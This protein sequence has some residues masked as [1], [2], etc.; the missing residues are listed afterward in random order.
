[1]RS[2]YPSLAT[3]FS[4]LSATY[5]PLVNHTSPF[6]CN[7]S[8]IASFPTATPTTRTSIIYS[9]ITTCTKSPA[10][11]CSATSDHEPINYWDPANRAP[12]Q[13]H[14]GP[15]GY[16]YSGPAF[17]KGTKDL[18]PALSQYETNGDSCWGTLD[19]PHLPPWVGA[20]VSGSYTS[21]S[22]YGNSSSA[23]PPWGNA[24]ATGTNPYTSAPHTNVTRYY[25]FT[26]SYMDIA[27]DGVKKPGLVINGG[28][29]GPLIEANW[30][31]WIE[32]K[33]TNLLDDEGTTLHWHGILQTEAPWMDGVPAVQMCPIPPTKS[34]TYR[35]KADLY[36]TSWYHSH[37]SAQYAGGALGPMII[38]GP[39]HA[40]Y[41]FD[42]GPVMLADWYH[43]AYYP[44]VEQTMSTGP[45]T[46]N[47]NLINGKMNYPCANTTLSCTADA[48][49]S[50]FRFQSGKK[51]LL[52]IINTSAD[53]V[54][55]FSIDNHTMSVIAND[56][57]PIVP[58]TT[59][60]VTLGVGQRADVIVDATGEAG[61]AFW[62]RASINGTCS[63]NDGISNE[64]VAAVYYE[65]A[66]TNA[67]PATA[68][69]M[70]EAQQ[71]YCGNDALSGL[72]PLFPLAAEETVSTSEDI[73]IEF[74][75]NGTNFVWTM[76]NSSFRGDYNDPILLDVKGG[77]MTFEPEWNV[78]NFGTNK[79]VRLVVYNYFA[80]GPHPMHLHGHNFWV[81]AEGFGTWDGHITNQ[82]NPSRRDVQLVHPAQD[83]DTPAYIVIQFEQDNPGV[84][85]LHCHIAWHVSAGL[86]ISVLERP[87]DI[88]KDMP[89]PDSMT[90]AC[91]VWWDYTDD[92]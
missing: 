88:V 1:M 56:F 23:L 17:L 25:D 92:T 84:W 90:E 75:S 3:A 48:G 12:Q 16:L 4:A 30:G 45:P 13:P 40:S 8:S 21:G 24:T 43:Q 59:G 2:H 62:M 61:E 15:Q 35:F 28:F 71:N 70:T 11:T 10:P 29:P 26:V 6:T 7:E 36:G 87:D 32:V 79:T 63:L 91:R 51:H 83:A 38:H 41:D 39:K 54:Q 69:Q 49:I 46:S 22:P 53:A 18:K 74:K 34:F 73:N 78:Y 27:P 80:F 44:D 50:K 85:P 60:V 42:L 5:S 58:Y 77:N 67:V 82:A 47:N 86:Y 65:S 72:V 20:P 66:D 33:V 19:A 31:D 76:N 89:I 9:T 14:G 37:Y 68:T 55:K 64:A 57:V 81:I 52:R